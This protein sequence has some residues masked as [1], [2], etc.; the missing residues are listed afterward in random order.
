MRF[1]FRPISV[2]TRIETEEPWT[3][4]EKNCYTTKY[5][6]SEDMTDELVIKTN[7]TGF[8]DEG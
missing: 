2:Y 8:F 1:K 6:T 4:A 7:L 3:Q 5:I